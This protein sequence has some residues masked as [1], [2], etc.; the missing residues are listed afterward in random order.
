MFTRVTLESLRYKYT[1]R[2][3]LQR[4]RMTSS[5]TFLSNSVRQATSRQREKTVLQVRTKR[6]G[7]SKLCTIKSSFCVINC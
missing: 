1:S 2:R 4:E 3:V 6:E 5:L 7:L